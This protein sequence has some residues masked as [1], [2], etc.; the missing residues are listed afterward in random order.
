MRQLALGWTVVA[1]WLCAA[2]VHAAT[3]HE[4]TEDEFMALCKQVSAEVCLPLN[5]E[6]EI[7]ALRTVPR[8]LTPENRIQ[9]DPKQ[10][11]ARFTIPSRSGADS[12]G[13]LHIPFPTPR[14]EVY[15]S[16][17]VRYPAELLAHRFSHNGGWKIFILGQGKEGCAPYEI[18]GGNAYYG[19]YPRFYYQCG[20]FRGVDVQNPTGNNPSQ[21]DYQPGGETSCMRQPDPAAKP[22]ARFE[23]DVWVTYQVHVD[24]TASF[25]EVWQTVRGVTKKIIEHPLQGFPLPAVKYEWLKLTPYDTGKNASED[26]PPFSLWYRRVMVTTKKIPMLGAAK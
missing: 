18:V 20:V 8:H 24:T 16:F 15:I 22:C 4:A 21:F 14:S 13:Q 3:P 7:A 1:T 5:S 10:K 17:D 12:A 6:S 11:A 25:L 26:H 19:G 2:S 23:A 9:W